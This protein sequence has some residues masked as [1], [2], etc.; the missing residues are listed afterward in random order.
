MPEDKAL[1]IVREKLKEFGIFL[2]SDIV[3]GT[4][5]GVSIIKS[6]LKKPFYQPINCAWHMVSLSSL[7]VLYKTILV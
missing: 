4:T 1:T 7:D 6:C 3:A 2:D 5:D